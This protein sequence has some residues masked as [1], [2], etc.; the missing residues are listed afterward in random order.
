[1]LTRVKTA[2]KKMYFHQA[3]V[4]SKNSPQKTLEV[5]RQLLGGNKKSFD[6]PSVMNTDEKRVFFNALPLDSLS[7][8]FI[9]NFSLGLNVYI[10]P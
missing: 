1:M 4:D 3:I 5:L 7:S 6:L 2:C 10:A 9:R 8:Y